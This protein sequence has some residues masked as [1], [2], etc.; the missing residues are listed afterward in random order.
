MEWLLFLGIVFIS[1][2][3][4]YLARLWGWIQ[5][6]QQHCE[7]CGKHRSVANIKY[8]KNTGMLFM[9]RWE[10]KQA[11]LCRACS[12]HL[13]LRMTTWTMAFGWWG[14]ISFFVNIFFVL[15]NFAM[16]IWTLTLP[17][18]KRHSQRLAL[19]NLEEQREYARLMLAAK[20]FDDVVHVLCHNTSAPRD[21]VEKWLRQ[22]QQN[23]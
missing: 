16:F 8:Y 22:M 2:G 4:L 15:N 9:F 6:H 14:F 7:A 19:E 3:T 5:H 21:V 20:D 17:H 18:S 11:T 10:S 12:T 13:F 1:I 23:S